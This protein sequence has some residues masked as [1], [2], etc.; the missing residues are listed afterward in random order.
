M[1]VQPG[2]VYRS[3]LAANRNDM[4]VTHV[5]DYR[6]EVHFTQRGNPGLIIMPWASFAGIAEYK[7]E[8]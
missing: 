3:L 6:E 1:I 4:T 7:G 8:K 2:Q 5:D